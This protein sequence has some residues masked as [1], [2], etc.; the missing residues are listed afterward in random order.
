MASS[1]RALLTSAAIV[2]LPGLALAAPGWELENGVEAPS[3][4]VAEP[5]ATDLNIDTV[6]LAC[7]QGGLQ[8]QLYLTDAGPLAP[9]GQATL[10]DDPAVDIVIDGVSYAAKLYFADDYVLVA[11]S[12]TSEGLSLG[13][14]LARRAA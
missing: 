5:S 7:E 10:K 14:G 4:A 3:Y 9:K 13:Q 1:L 6:V 8:L 2:A 12:A 11:D